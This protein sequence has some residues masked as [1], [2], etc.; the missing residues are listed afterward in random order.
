MCSSPNSDRRR[1]AGGPVGLLAGRRAGQRVRQGPPAGPHRGGSAR[2][3]RS[4]PSRWRRKV[5][6][7]RNDPRVALSIETDKRNAMG[8]NECLVIHG[9]GAGV[10]HDLAR[11]NVGH[12]VLERMRTLRFIR[13]PADIDSVSRHQIGSAT[14]AAPGHCPP[15]PVAPLARAAPEIVICSPAAP[16]QL[17]KEP[18]HFD[19]RE[20][21]SPRARAPP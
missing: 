13:P 19:L 10:G 12:G 16:G 1:P 11:A 20:L 15:R 6:N 4:S 8:L 18:A 5:R 14:P 9:T 3:A 2:A 21:R 7:I 17:E